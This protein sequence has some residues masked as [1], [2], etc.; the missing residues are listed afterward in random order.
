M[1]EVAKV[2]A[3]SELKGQLLQVK[4]Q[5]G[6]VTLTFKD[7]TACLG[8]RSVNYVEL[9]LRLLECFLTSFCIAG[10]DICTSSGKSWASWS[11]CREYIVELREKVS[12]LGMSNNRSAILNF[13]ELRQADEDICVLWSKY[14]RKGYT[15]SE[16]M[17]KAEA[18]Q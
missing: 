1:F 2:H 8:Y 14:M 7:I 6:D 16:A 10:V 11:Q 4:K 5:M 18:K 3:F 17:V 9:Y 13:Q 15:M 12:P